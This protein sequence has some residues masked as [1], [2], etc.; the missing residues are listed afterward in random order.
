MRKPNPT[1]RH[2][3]RGFTFL[4]AVLGLALLGIIGG[5][6][7]GVL[8]YAWRVE[9]NARQTLGAA[10]VA[11]R[12]LISYLD[13]STSP[14]KLPDTIAYQEMTFRWSLDTTRVSIKDTVPSART[15]RDGSATIQEALDKMESVVVIA[16]I[17]DGTPAS[18]VPGSTPGYRLDRVIDPFTFR[19]ADSIDRLINDPERRDELFQRI[20]GLDTESDEASR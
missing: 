4:E 2:A 6:I 8:G 12:V 3:S 20:I 11:N 13:D 18:L 7:F 1:A 9:I 17:D 14:R 10:E 16:W 19:S 5:A 15:D